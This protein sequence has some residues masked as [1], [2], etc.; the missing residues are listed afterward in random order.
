MRE[1]LPLDTEEREATTRSLLP[2]KGPL[3]GGASQYDEE[4][5]AGGSEGEGRIP[6]RGR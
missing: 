3:A 5:A 2:R 1:Y 6:A 4:S